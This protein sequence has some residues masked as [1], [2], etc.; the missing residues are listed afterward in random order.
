MSFEPKPMTEEEKA[1]DDLRRAENAAK[2]G[3]L[4]NHEHLFTVVVEWGEDY[5]VSKEIAK[6]MIFN[7]MMSLIPT[8]KVATKLKCEGCS[9]VQ[10]L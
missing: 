1:S 7:G 4:V 3:H 6:E 2:H 9:E 8:K 5:S 10:E